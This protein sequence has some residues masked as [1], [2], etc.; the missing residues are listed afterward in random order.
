MKYLLRNVDIRISS[1]YNKK[2]GKLIGPSNWHVTWEARQ[3]TFIY[4]LMKVLD[5]V[6][7]VISLGFIYTSFSM[8]LTELMLK[9]MMDYA[10]E[11]SNEDQSR[12]CD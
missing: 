2:Y 10:R 4:S 11:Y 12:I 5:G 6:L 1:F 8:D 3:L 9:R 7:G